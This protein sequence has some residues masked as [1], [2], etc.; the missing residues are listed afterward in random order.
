VAKAITYTLTVNG[1]A[2]SAAVLNAVKQIEVV[3]ELL[4]RGV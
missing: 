3:R 2:A 4:Q 1:T